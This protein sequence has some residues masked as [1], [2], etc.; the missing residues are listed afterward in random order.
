MVG[1]SSKGRGVKRD[2]LYAEQG[3]IVPDSGVARSYRELSV[4]GRVGCKRLLAI[5]APDRWSPVRMAGRSFG[6]FGASG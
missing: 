1:N 4:S 5:T 2:N 3:Q 6:T